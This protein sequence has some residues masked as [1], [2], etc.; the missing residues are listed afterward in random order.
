MRSL[1]LGSGALDRLP[2]VRRADR[3]PAHL[4]IEQWLAQAVSNG[5]FRP[6][7]KLPVE[8]EFAAALGVSRATLRQAWASLEARGVLFRRRGRG[9]G[10]FVAEPRVECDLTGLLSFTEQMRRAHR[11]PGATVVH[12]AEVPAPVHVAA[13]LSLARGDEVVRIERVRSA[14]ASPVALECSYLPAQLFPGLLGHDL[15]QSL[16]GILRDT[17]AHAPHTSHEALEPVLCDASTA[18]RL[19]LAAGQPV[20]RIE[21]TAFTVG[22]LPVEYAS[23]V[24][25]CDR[26]RLTVRTGLAAP[27]DAAPPGR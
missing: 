6:G 18:A 19:D 2:V 3:V 26:V 9:G 1:T 23:D 24:Y 13:A 12:A 27:E 4:Q 25:R 15:S 7:D 5:M 8:G 20:M 10:T 17:Y 11:E 22:G 21:R 14:N 16:Y